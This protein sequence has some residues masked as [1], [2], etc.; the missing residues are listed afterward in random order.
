MSDGGQ[1]VPVSLTRLERNEAAT[2]GVRCVN[3]KRYVAAPCFP[4]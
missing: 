4:R 3:A 1:K 2:A